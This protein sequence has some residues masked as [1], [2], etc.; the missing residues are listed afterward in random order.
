MRDAE[1]YEWLGEHG[2]G[3]FGRVLRAHDKQL[4][5]DVA[6]KELLDGGSAAEQRFHREALITARLEHPGIVPV[7]EAGRWNDGTSFYAM[8]LV[9]GRP[10]KDVIGAA[11]GVADRLGLVINVIAVAD[12][13]AYAHD[14][15][16]IH[17]DLKPANVIIGE[18]GETV[19][20][21]WGLA[22]LLDAPAGD[23]SAEPERSAIGNDVTAAGS[24]LG[25]PAYMAPEQY[26]GYADERSDIYALGGM[27]RHVITGVPPHGDPAGRP[28]YPRGVPRDLTAIVERAMAADPA[29]RYSSARA[30]ADDLRRFQR[31]VP[32]AAR[33]YSLAARLALGVARHRV[34]ALAFMGGL[35]VLA[36]TL[37]VLLSKIA[38]ERAEAVRAGAVAEDA[39][40]STQGAKDELLLQNAE[41]LLRSDPTAAVTALT[42][43]RGDN[44]IRRD[45]LVAEAMGRGVARRVVA[46][47]NSGVW[48]V[49]A[50]ARSAIYSLSEDQTLR[51]TDG[52]QTTTVARDIASAVVVAYAPA[53][54]LLAYARAPS[55]IALFELA[56]HR[57]VAI[58]TET[59][60]VIAFSPD[61]TRLVELSAVGRLRVWDVAAAPIQL[62]DTIVA[63]A[64]NVMFAGESRI[65]VAEDDAIRAI[66]IND[67]THFAPLAL[68]TPPTAW[69][70]DATGV[71][72]ALGDGRGTITLVSLESAP[73]ARLIALTT[74]PVCGKRITALAFV[75][76]SELVAY[77]C[78]DG[79]VGVARADGAQLVTVDS[80]STAGSAS[81]LRVDAAG[82]YLVACDEAN[83]VFAYDIATRMVSRY[84]GH[85]ARVTFIAAQTADLP[86]IVS[87]DSS[88]TYRLWQPP[89]RAARIVLQTDYGLSDMQFTPDGERL[90]VT[91]VAGTARVVDLATGAATALPGHS[92]LVHGPVFTSDGRAMVTW[93]D[94]GTARVWRPDGT[95]LAVFTGHRGAISRVEPVDGDRFAS[96]GEDGRLLLWSMDDTNARE[97]FKAPAQLSILH[98][99]APIGP[100]V[101]SDARGALWAVT[102]D[103]HARAIRGADGA[104]TALRPSRDG[105]RLA[106]GSHDGTVTVYETTGW[107]MVATHRAPAAIWR[108][109]FDRLAHAVVF[110]SIDGHVHV[111]P[112]DSARRFG[113]DD[114]PLRARFFQLSPDDTMLA[115]MVAATGGMWLFEI[116]GQRWTYFHDH[117]IQVSVGIFS[118]DSRWFA[119][120]DG[121]G[122]V[123][124]R[125]LTAT[126]ASRP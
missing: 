102:L 60:D 98:A 81:T 33:R 38:T 58:D 118:P 112:L 97:L 70:T 16:V 125:D 101:V 27:L 37:A 120:C 69:A 3:G 47:H 32:V 52:A 96:A 4:G 53:R 73:Q 7:H 42:G 57:T 45:L 29:L 56:T 80:F 11:H 100:L 40:R 43:Y 116:A 103:G 84:V 110:T 8:K 15:N 6:I 95:A 117:Q 28:G 31:R 91:G 77:S 94:D 54:R 87:A 64:G 19:V 76:N 14:R 68:R 90:V 59:P 17:R 92:D 74:L 48:F 10:L 61:E 26:A 78:R 119:S 105:A 12:A 99:L 89:D 30:F 18:F 63:G 24:I 9:A 93:S 55:G 83:T 75:P 121:R 62:T 13:I 88:G 86:A 106:V 126:R 22:K 2:R 50:D 107:T 5:R 35:V 71:R 111:L 113:W 82:R 109:Q 114:L 51:M 46:A 41:L 124:L 36:I 72:F 23:S 79:V 25:T 44:S 66:G 20:I 123:T 122:T 104:I 1:R 115:G 49:G 34:L 21:D 108:L 39:R 85:G 65:L 67:T